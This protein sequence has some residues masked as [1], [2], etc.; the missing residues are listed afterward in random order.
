MVKMPKNLTLRANT[1]LLTSSISTPAF[2]AFSLFCIWL[3]EL[4]RD[5]TADRKMQ[6]VVV[7]RFLSAQCKSQLEVSL[8]LLF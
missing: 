1:K 7:L 8:L 3:L 2:R 5:I 6:V 4:H